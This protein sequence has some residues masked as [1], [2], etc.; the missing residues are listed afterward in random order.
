MSDESPISRRPLGEAFDRF[1]DRVDWSPR[2]RAMPAVAKVAD[3]AV[4]RHERRFH[5]LDKT[6]GPLYDGDQILN[7]TADELATV[8]KVAARVKY[9][10]IV[11]VV[12]RLNSPWVE[13]SVATRAV[14]AEDEPTAYAVERYA[15]WRTTLAVYRIGDDGAVEDDPIQP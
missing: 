15:L 8:V 13:F 14:E 4:A 6:A 1:A 7:A 11:Q 3:D 2:E 5:A 12:K 10:R 9:A